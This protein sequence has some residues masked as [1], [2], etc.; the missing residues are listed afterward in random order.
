MREMVPF[1]DEETM[2][3]M[4]EFGRAYMGYACDSEQL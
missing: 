3:M 2:A 1:G 4:Q